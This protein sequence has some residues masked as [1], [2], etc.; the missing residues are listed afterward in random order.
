M[1]QKRRT[2][3]PAGADHTSDQSTDETLRDGES[4][5]RALFESMVQG[6]VYQSSDGKIISANPAAERI[7]GLSLDRMQGRT[8]MDPRWRAIHEDGSDFPGEERRA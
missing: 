4:A 6:V 7:L 2:D 5:Y 3:E 8:W 1:G